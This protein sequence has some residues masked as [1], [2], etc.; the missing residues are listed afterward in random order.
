MMFRFHNAISESFRRGA[1]FKT[2][3]FFPLLSG[4]FL[5]AFFLHA[6]SLPAQSP[7]KWSALTGYT[8][9]RPYSFFQGNTD[10]PDHYGSFLAGVS[11]SKGPRWR[12]ESGIKITRF[13]EK[14]ESQVVSNFY[15]APWL[16]RKQY[17]QIGIPLR[18]IFY[19][20]RPG[21]RISPI[22]GC[23]LENRFLQ[24]FQMRYFIFPNLYET[25]YK[26]S[27][28]NSLNYSGA[29]SGLV[30]ADL[31]IANVHALR[32]AAEF[33]Y[34]FKDAETYVFFNQLDLPAEI[35][36]SINWIFNL[37]KHR[38]PTENKP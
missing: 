34:Y 25:S 14:S 9:Q 29:L 4:L 12:F 38:N 26:F 32:L 1:A 3:L 17:T 2:R 28:D 22:I 10:N 30:G 36:F 35:C 23:G 16:Y 13:S 27:L 5:M 18:V 20:I 31:L 21:G 19:P 33:H 6:H 11:A 15:P 7:I 8:F 24:S 37:S